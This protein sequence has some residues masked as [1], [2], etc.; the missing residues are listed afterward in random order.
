[1]RLANIHLS[2]PIPYPP[3]LLLVGTMDTSEFVWWDSDLLAQTNIIPWDESGS[4]WCQAPA[5]AIPAGEAVFLRSLIRS[6]QTALRKLLPILEQQNLRQP[7]QPLIRMQ[8]LLD[9]HGVQSSRLGLEEAIIYL[10]NCWSQQGHG[11]FDPSSTQNLAVALDMAIAQT[12]LPRAARL[13][14]RSSR[15]YEEVA[16]IINGQFPRAKLSL[17][18]LMVGDSS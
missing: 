4:S 1:M 12:Y 2:E 10:A 14:Q 17:D 3:N 15:L 5:E 11:L 18:A 8:A 13:I 9:H 16:K 6:E 7:I